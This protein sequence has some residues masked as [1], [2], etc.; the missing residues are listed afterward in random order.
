[1]RA[2]GESMGTGKGNAIAGS[3]GKHGG[4]SP[5][6]IRSVGGARAACLAAGLATV[7]AAGA[8]AA[9]MQA[10]PL[11]A[12]RLTDGMFK[13][14]MDLNRKVMDEMG[15]E[16][17]LHCFRLQAKLP[18]SAKPFGGWATPEPNGAFPGQYEGHYL[19]ALATLTAHTGD[20]VL[21]ERLDY[22]VG[23]LA[24]CQAAMGGKY[25]FASP[26]EEF[27]P[28][29]I[30]GVAWYRMH[31]VM[32]G[33]YAAYAYGGNAQ[34]LTILKGMA[35][36]VKGRMDGYSS[37][38]WAKVRSIESGGMAEA[39]YDLYTATKDPVHLAMAK[40]WEE[41]VAM[42]DPLNQG[43]D[44]VFGHANTYLA[45][46][47]GAARVA[48]AEG[49][50]YYL[51]AME[52][53]WE[54]TAGS[55][56]RAY[57]TGGVSVHEGLP[58]ARVLSNT[59]EKLPSETCV[60]F[61][62]MKVTRSLFLAT[63]DPKYMDY[64]ERLLF[65]S[66]L[67]SQDPASGWKS[68]YQPL[69]ANT[70]K[71]FRDY[72]TGA[73]C[74]NGSGLE[75]FAKLGQNVYT[76]DANTL[77]V[78]QFVSST[79]T[80]AGRGIALEQTTT[81][82][83]SPAS[84]IT[85]HAVKPVAMRIAIRAPAWCQGFRVSVAGAAAN[86][87][88]GYA[89]LD[90]TWKEGDRIEIGLPM[91]FATEGMPDRP[92]QLAFLYGPIVMVGSKARPWRSELIGD[93][94]DKSS[95]INNLESS[96]RRVGGGLAFAA[97]DGA[98]RE[99]GLKPYYSVAAEEFFTGYFD[100]TPTPSIADDGNLAL[101]KRSEESMPQAPGDNLAC[102][103]RGARALDGM[104]G[105]W[106]SKWLSGG[107][108]PSWLKI[109]L[110]K[111]Y[112]LTRTEFWPPPTGDGDRIKY[113][114]YRIETSRDGAQ[115]AAYADR[116]AN[117]AFAN[118]A[119]VDKIEAIARYIRITL[120][121]TP[122]QIYNGAPP[123]IGEFK[124]YGTPLV[125]DAAAVPSART[126]AFILSVPGFGTLMAFRAGELKRL[127]ILDLRGR[128][129]RSLPVTGTAITW[130]GKDS[131]GQPI[132]SGALVVRATTSEGVFHKPVAWSR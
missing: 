100:V 45:K 62:M 66:I 21:K 109:D 112:N 28:D 81:F 128:A 5:K 61:N 119:Y 78:N 89:V 123:D 75:S 14:A 25:M 1:M 74:C 86:M 31:K 18:T 24:K 16:R 3:V 64:A 46:I 72:I 10:F 53:F 70:V 106:Y 43:K 95:W 50:A 90:R 105:S 85:V 93:I 35:E 101:G 13:K 56:R 91:A 27:E 47:V 122:G 2:K 120:L 11:T 19:S 115:W 33:L 52:N 107:G 40:Q 79:V 59:Q 15:P 68:Y 82:P 57:V 60:T 67:G 38:G 97:S 65:N 94:A 102:F 77:F 30:D 114:K 34:A 29:R 87:E 8:D 121:E 17:V 92:S 110:E 6:G 44:V 83:E 4:G 69:Y 36:W 127:E 58:G 26:P 125:P 73:F 113:Y 20:P 32:E 7:M 22:M 99:L 76:H 49:D 48:E 129:I 124:A 104:T 37:S 51:K 111:E 71:D 118:P 80:W 130:D 84:G 96:F 117:A 54:F 108:F 126:R 132:P 9:P 98:R 116:T 12:V 63:G 41:R 39:L 55:G 103:G 131:R 88:G 42:L 23:E